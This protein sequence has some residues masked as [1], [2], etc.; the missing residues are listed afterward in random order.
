MQ[1]KFVAEVPVKVRKPK[2]I[3]RER[4]RR[5]KKGMEIR[6]KKVIREAQ[7]YGVTNFIIHFP[8][9]LEEQYK[10]QLMSIPE[11]YKPSYGARIPYNPDGTIPEEQL[12]FLSVYTVR[13]TEETLQLVAKFGKTNRFDFDS[14]IAVRAQIA[15]TEGKDLERL[16]YA[17]SYPELK[18]PG[19]SFGKNKDTGKPLCFKNFQKAGIQYALETKRCFIAEEMGL[20][21]TCEAIGVIACDLENVG[22]SGIKTPWLIVVPASLRINWY[23]ECRRWFPKKIREHVVMIK[24]KNMAM[25]TVKSKINR[26]E[27]KEVPTRTTKAFLAENQIFIMTYDKIH[28][29]RDLLETVAW[30]GIIFDESHYLKGRSTQR[31]K[32]CKEFVHTVDPEF[33]LLLSGTPLM[34]KPLDLLN[35]LQTLSRLND[36]GGYNHFLTRYCTMSTVDTSH[37]S[38]VHEIAKR[39]VVVEEASEANDNTETVDLTRMNKVVSIDSAL[40]DE[41]VRKLYANM[42]ALNKSLRSLCYVRREKI[43][44]LKE[45]PEKSRQTLTFEITN[46]KDYESIEADVIGYLMDKVAKDEKFMKSIRKYSKGKQQALI[47]QKKAERAAS[48][49]RAQA[50]VRIENLKQCAAIGKLKAVKEWIEDF[51]ESGKKLVVFATHNMILNE[52]EAMFP[53]ALSIRSNMS[54]EKRDNAVT[55]FQ[56]NKKKNLI[57]IGLKLALGLTLTAASDTFTI[58]FGWTPAVHDQA[59]DRVHRIGQKNAVTAYYGVA[60][61]TIEEAIGRLIEKKRRIVNAV[62]DGDPLKDAGTGS[63]LGDL[64]GELTGGYGLYS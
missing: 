15:T 27:K 43:D 13:S 32:V 1:P 53:D 26:F 34:N 22:I 56:E 50:L 9:E 12:T 11:M 62:A 10:P 49:E 19:F 5:A 64:L 3:I 36:F 35:Q 60:S 63:V 59:E 20:G 40:Q 39:D 7:K 21:K 8:E 48:G 54:A 4:K 52:L 2:P 47:A 28:R 57:F 16:S 45:L 6:S 25:R 46:R 37:V 14:D 33:V 42:I 31:S 44:V 55:E 61:G 29:F 18:L 38:K 41:A 58:E 30:R 23:K 24:N 51:L 17:K